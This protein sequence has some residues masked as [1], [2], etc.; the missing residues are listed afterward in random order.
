M[1]KKFQM[2]WSDDSL[3][4]RLSYASGIIRLL[5]EM[6]GSSQSRFLSILPIGARVEFFTRANGAK[7]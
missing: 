7:I 5:K 2:G 6:C 1:R 4:R 3:A